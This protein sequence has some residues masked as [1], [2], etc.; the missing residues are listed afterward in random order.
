[1]KKTKRILSLLLSA[2][3]G[4]SFA[5]APYGQ[6]VSA[7]DVYTGY[8]TARIDSLV[9]EFEKILEKE[10]ITPEMPEC[11]DR[12]IH[13]ADYAYY[14]LVLS[15]VQYSEEQTS[16]NFSE[17]SAMSATCRYVTG[18]IADVMR[19]A[20][21]S[22]HAEYVITLMNEGYIS[23][24]TDFKVRKAEEDDEILDKRNA[25]VQ[26]YIE[27]LSGTASEREKELACAEIYLDLVKHYNSLIVTEGCS[28]IDY[29]YQLYYRDYSPKDIAVLNDTAANCLGDAY[30]KL[31]EHASQSYRKDA[32]EQVFDDNFDIV[33]QFAN[34]VSD[35]LRESAEMVTERDLYRTG[36]LT[37]S[38][39]VSYTTKLNYIRSAVIYQ[40]VRGDTK[41]LA[42][43]THEFGHFNAL[44]QDETPYLYIHGSN[45]DI[46]EVQSQGLEVLYTDF[47][48]SIYG[49]NDEYFRMN[50][51]AS[52]LVAVAGGFQ[53]NEFEN[54]VFEHADSMTP[55]DVIDKYNELAAK[56]QL[57]KVPF[58]Q[59][60]HFFQM[61]GYYI[62]YAVS[63][64]AALDLWNVMYSD[65]DKAADM[66]T[67]ISHV[68]I[69]D[70]TGFSNAL[71]ESGFDNVLTEEFMTGNLNDLVDRL[72]DGL[73]YGDADRNG[74]VG[75]AD[76]LY[77]VARIISAS[78]CSEDDLKSCDLS[79]DGTVNAKD[80]LKLKRIIAS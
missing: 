26:K 35:D 34:R 49:L 10:K 19:K 73:V 21:V 56:Y 50:E 41:D 1:M 12:I 24:N 65:F 46:A 23:A 2:A 54:Y 63:A 51:A 11:Y 60:S 6:P 17:Y 71:A 80:L 32:A 67:K 29:A 70:G 40:C 43:T 53:G 66:Y 5:G 75:T 55:Q 18:R 59:V 27:T 9:S 39:A 57:Y 58:Y 22:P 77:L 33:S 4:L 42:V 68:S 13:E 37:N 45:L 7:A 78:P 28:Y 8:D 61:P 14:Q 38:E 44:R 69:Y 25:L 16:E 74:T 52:M 31:V 64:L 36:T 48:D 15:K 72:T 30:R 76:L 3:A 79:G 62:S 47:Y 20:L